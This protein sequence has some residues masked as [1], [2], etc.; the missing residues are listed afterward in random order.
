MIYIIFCGSEMLAVG[1]MAHS[2][3][4]PPTAAKRS[5]SATGPERSRNGAI[6]MPPV[7]FDTDVVA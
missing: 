1:V 6:P 2:V 5:V 4:A 3:A 7:I